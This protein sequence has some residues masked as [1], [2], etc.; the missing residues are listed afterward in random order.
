[1][2]FLID[3]NILISLEP[4]ANTTIEPGANEAAEVARLIQQSG[5]QVVVHPLVLEDIARDTNLARRQH[6]E[7]VLKKYPTLDSP[8][9]LTTTDEASL[10]TARPHSNDW[11]DNHLLVAVAR[12]AVD[13]LIT[14]DQGIHRRAARLNLTDRVLTT[15]D[16]LAMLRA[17]FPTTPLPPPAVRSVKAHTLRND[18]PIFDS[19]RTDYQG[20]DDW[21]ARCKRSDRP[22]W[23]IDGNGGLAAVCIVKHEKEPTFG[24][25]GAILKICSFKVA[26]GHLGARYG[27]LLLKAV[28]T[29]AHENHFD[30]IYVTAFEKHAWL[31]ALFHEF[32]FT[33]AADRTA[34]GELV[35]EKQARAPKD[36]AH[37]ITALEYAIRFGPCVWSW[38]CDHTWVIPIQ[39]R[40]DRILFPDLQEQQDLS[41]G[42]QPS[43]NAIR[44]A[45]LSR[46][47]A[48]G[49]V[50]GDVLAFYR[51]TTSRSIRNLGV[52]EN[53]IASSDA[54]KIQQFVA[55]RTVYSMDEIR[56]MCGGSREV[57]AIRFRQVLHA[58][59]E[60]PFRQLFDNHVLNAPPQ[61]IVRV[62]PEGTQ[63]L[64]QHLPQS[65]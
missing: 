48:R 43:G 11:V 40:Y 47:P 60:I 36:G 28:F 24:M 50:P 55:R 15:T 2:K 46:S 44:K 18:D 37:S 41:I 57:L 25:T 35:L 32:G 64:K 52:V 12:D 63:W 34:L 17:L 7:H 3:T 23:I 1:M 42:L 61:S 5:N 21:L 19:F 56:S 10:G 4:T 6:R 54:E 62:R 26:D 51:S 33:I 22:T 30:W 45:Y 20:F 49:L 8:P 59:P 65:R 14:Q 16:A 39:P 53:W 31:L 38:D 27:E 9:V 29:Y 13:H 58:F